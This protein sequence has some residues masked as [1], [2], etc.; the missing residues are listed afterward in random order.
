MNGNGQLGWVEFHLHQSRFTC[1]SFGVYL[2]YYGLRA[3]SSHFMHIL[4]DP[5]IQ[6]SSTGEKQKLICKVI[7]HTGAL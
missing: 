5:I 4:L 1:W 7:R 6:E 3:I 2:C